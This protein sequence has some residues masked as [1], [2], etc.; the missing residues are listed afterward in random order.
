MVLQCHS[1]EGAERGGVNVPNKLLVHGDDMLTDL[2]DLA[3]EDGDVG[4]APVDGGMD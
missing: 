4:N 1:D 2:I 3:L